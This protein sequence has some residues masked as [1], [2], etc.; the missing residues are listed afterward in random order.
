M[1]NTT[2]RRAI[3]RTR[4]VVYRAEADDT[5]AKTADSVAK[6]K[7]GGS[8]VMVSNFILEVLTEELPPS[9]IPDVLLTLKEQFQNFFQENGL[10]YKTIESF[11]SAR[12]FGVYVEELDRKQKD[13]EEAKKGPSKKVAFLNDDMLKPT[14][15]LEGFLLSNSGSLSDIEIREISRIPY[16]FMKKT[17]P[18][19]ATLQLLSENIPVILSRMNFK[20]PMRWAD[21][22]NRFVRPVHGFLAMFGTESVPFQLFSI[23]SGVRTYG[24]RFLGKEIVLSRAEDY[25]ESLKQEFVW[26]RQKERE[27]FATEQLV[28][29]SKEM[30]V[31]IPIDEELLKEVTWLTEYPQAVAGKY[32]PEFLDL[33]M[34][35]LITTLKHHQRT[36]PVLKHARLTGEFVSF[37]DNGKAAGKNVVKGYEKVIN[38]RLADAKFFFLEDRKKPLRG[39]REGL[40]NVLFQKGLGSYFD[41]VERTRQLTAYLCEV[42]RLPTE[43]AQTMDEAAQLSKCD[44]LTSMVYEFPELQGTMGRIYTI[45]EGEKNAVFSHYKDVATALEEQYS[46]NV[47]ETIYGAILSISDK[48]DVLCGNLWLGNVPT[49]SKDA[50]GLR[51]KLFQIIEIIVHYQWEVDLPELFLRGLTPFQQGETRCSNVLLPEQIGKVFQE[52]VQS[53]LEFF[54]SGSALLSPG[55][56]CRTTSDNG[57]GEKYPLLTYDVIRAVLHHFAQPVRVVIAAESLQRYKS[58]PSFLELCTLFERVHNISKNHESTEYDARLFEL[59]AEKALLNHLSEI[60]SAVKNHISHLNYLDAMTDLMKL[61]DSINRYFEE[62]FV[63]SD[64]EDVKLTRLGFLKSLDALFLSV[65]DLSKVEKENNPGKEAVGS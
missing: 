39:Y 28:V 19:K 36:F 44:L 22:E 65:A 3:Y 42:L 29:L 56:S 53:R 9:E 30:G 54:L 7:A 23:D 51:K 49:G 26:V 58:E 21:G 37:M 6:Y 11:V 20:R 45:L 24:H 55:A 33:P 27:A 10:A 46:P 17:I 63:M 25:F 40:K 15:A 43:V 35:V 14:K 32:K 16:V 41:K 12:R 38:A 57:I 2:L 60:Q 5:V 31:T 34:E 4:G 47:P 61:K 62:V 8:A 59:D 48:M 50:Y 18:G 52:L 13:R 64:R 1:N